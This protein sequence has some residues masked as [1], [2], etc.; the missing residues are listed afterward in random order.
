MKSFMVAET[1]IDGVA[2][3]ILMSIFSYAHHSYIDSGRLTPV[4]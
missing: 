3:P 1:F 4:Y 2:V